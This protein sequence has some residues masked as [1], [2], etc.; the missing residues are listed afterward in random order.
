[1][2]CVQDRW[3]LYI[4]IAR[5]S[6]IDDGEQPPIGRGRYLPEGTRHLPMKQATSGRLRGG[7][8][9]KVDLA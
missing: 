4:R 7:R 6:G 9:A 2:P 3:I 5:V 1:M 8:T